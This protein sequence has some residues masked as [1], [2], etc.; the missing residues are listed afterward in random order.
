MYTYTK[1]T[2]TYEP[3]T[4]CT[5]DKIVPCMYSWQPEPYF[6]HLTSMG[7]GG[8]GGLLEKMASTLPEL[9]VDLWEV[10]PWSPADRTVQAGGRGG[11]ASVLPHGGQAEL[12]EGVSTVEGDRFMEDGGTYG[13][14]EVLRDAGLAAQFGRRRGGRRRG[15]W[16]VERRRR[17]RW[18]GLWLR[19][20]RRR[21]VERIFRVV[22]L[23]C[24]VV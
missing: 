11:L 1:G 15:R 9:D 12:A 6:L 7:G 21:R 4:F 5:L 23:L 14:H 13:A 2:S 24:R 16:G 17:G 8:G 22:C 20:R 3:C 10:P 19:R 18:Q